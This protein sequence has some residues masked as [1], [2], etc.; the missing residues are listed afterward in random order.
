MGWEL[1]AEVINDALL[2]SMVRIGYK[3][4]RVFVLDT[5]S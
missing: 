5:K 3:I 1:C 2:C 4:D